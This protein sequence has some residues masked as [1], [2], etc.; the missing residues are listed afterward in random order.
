MN[1]QRIFLLCSLLC[2]TLSVL[3]PTSLSWFLPEPKYLGPLN[4]DS[5]EQQERLSMGLAGLD[6]FPAYFQLQTNFSVRSL[7]K[8]GSRKIFSTAPD[9]RGLRLD[10]DFM[11][12]LYLRLAS[13]SDPNDPQADFTQLVKASDR[14]DNNKKMSLEIFFRHRTNEFVVTVNEEQKVLFETE[15][16]ESTF[17]VSR[18]IPD[19]SLISLGG[20]AATG[21]DGTITD[22]V[23]AS[24]FEDSRGT[25]FTL[26]L[27]LAMTG[28]TL[29]LLSI[30]YF[31]RREIV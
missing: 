20:D 6:A 3:L 22:F 30:I 19:L 9:G 17:D 10:V 25:T 5:R 8:S 15:S 11:G 2:F 31:R 21:I 16:L 18:I 26:K 1:K 28:T 13:T 27:L 23:I 24:S 7:P 4:F 14:F 29:L 12:T